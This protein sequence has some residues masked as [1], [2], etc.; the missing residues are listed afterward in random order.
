MFAI[1]ILG[2]SNGLYFIADTHGSFEL[3]LLSR[4]I[5]GLGGSK[6]LHRRYII[7]YLSRS[8]WD[9]YFWW[10]SFVGFL[11]MVVGPLTYAAV[12]FSINYENKAETLSD[13]FLMPGYLNSIVWL[14]FFVVILVLFQD[15]P[16]RKVRTTTR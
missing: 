16:M 13:D 11:G 4:V 15:P 1:V 6:V 14:V 7:G 12:I 2:V 5:F 3:L 9:R 8:H 10:L